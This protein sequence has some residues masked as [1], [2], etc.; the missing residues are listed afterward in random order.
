VGLAG[1]QCSAGDG[2]RG[3]DGGDGTER[4]HGC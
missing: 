3:V 2:T 4:S 1:L